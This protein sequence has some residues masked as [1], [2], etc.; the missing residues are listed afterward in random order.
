[1][2][3]TST[4]AREYLAKAIEVIDLLG[5]G[6]AIKHPQLVAAFMQTCAIDSIAGTLEREMSYLAETIARAIQESA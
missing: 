4:T 6:Y 5:R 1:M 2:Q 3:Q